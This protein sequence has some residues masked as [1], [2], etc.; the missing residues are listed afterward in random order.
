MVLVAAIGVWVY[1]DFS[2]DVVLGILEASGRVEG[3]QVA[4]GAKVSGR[5]VHLPIREGQTLRAGDVIAELSSAQVK[6]QLEQA[7]HELHTAREEVDQ[8]LAHIAVLER[9]VEARETAV[10]LAEDESRA[11]IGKAEA[12]LEASRAQLPQAEAELH[13]TER[14]LDRY[15]QLLAKDLIAPQ[16]VDEARATYQIAR[17]TDEVTRKRIAQAEEELKLARAS[18]TTVQLRKRELAR[19]REQLRESRAASGAAKARVQTLEAR[20]AE[21]RAD[22]KDTRVVAPFDGTVLQKLVQ[23][24]QVVAVGTPLVTFVDMAKLYVKVYLPEKQ[25]AKVRLGNPS[26]VYVDAFPKKYFQ[27]SVSEV[28]QQAEFTPRDVHMKEERVNLVFAVK[29][30]LDHPQGLLKPGMPADAKIRWQPQSPWGDAP[31]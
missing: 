8:A 25:I 1:R 3:D 7:E 24:G 22:I 17:A 26:R 18:A 9:E 27:A 2:G 10:Q 4:L 15:Q 14:D 29:L 21:A 31:G 30:A 12:A 16:Q 11:R 5:I 23:E 6:A 28:S 13:R 19:A 20:R